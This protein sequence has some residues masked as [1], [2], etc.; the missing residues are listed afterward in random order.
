MWV[1]M[2]YYIIAFVDSFFVLDLML[3]HFCS[4]GL[5][6]GCRRRRKRPRGWQE[7]KFWHMMKV[8]RAALITFEDSKKMQLVKQMTAFLG[9][10]LSWAGSKILSFQGGFHSLSLFCYIGF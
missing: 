10:P 2:G 3:C 4:T 9:S 8:V 1:S 7:V 6:C 5:C